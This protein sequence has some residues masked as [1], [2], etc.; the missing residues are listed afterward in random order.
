[1]SGARAASLWDGVSGDRLTAAALVDFG[2]LLTSFIQACG[3]HNGPQGLAKQLA[4][5]HHL[6]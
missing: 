6:A 4:F 2:R 5:R 1:M 3:R